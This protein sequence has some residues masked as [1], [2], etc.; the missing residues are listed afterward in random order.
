MTGWRLECVVAVR[1]QSAE[2]LS[3]ALSRKTKVTWRWISAQ[4]ADR[5]FTRRTQ[6]QCLESLNASNA[7]SSQLPLS[8]WMTANRLTLNSS[9]TE[10]IFCSSDS[11]YTTVHLTPLTLLEI[12]ASSLTN[13]LLAWTKL[14]L[15]KACCCHIRQLCCIHPYLD[16]L[17]ACTIATSVVHSKPDYCNSLYYKL[18]KSQLSF[19]QQIQNSE[20]LVLSWKL[21]R[22]VISLPSYALSTGSGWLNASNAG[23]S[24]LPT[25]FLQL[26][27]LHTFITL[28]PFNVIAMLTLHPSLLLL[29][30]FH[31]PL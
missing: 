28:S 15:F 29:G 26:P 10:F 19:L 7:S 6:F 4:S 13:I 23:F 1:I 16:S 8:S 20:F 5:H 17:T 22:P 14:H 3:L 12:L 21:L 18:S 2:A 31:H 25:K 9:K 24:H 11:K 27:N 30:N